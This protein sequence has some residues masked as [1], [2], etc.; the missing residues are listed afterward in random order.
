MTTDYCSQVRPEHWIEEIRD[1]RELRSDLGLGPPDLITPIDTRLKGNR[2]N[3]MSKKDA[4]A[5]LNELMNI[6]E[7]E[8]K[9][10]PSGQLGVDN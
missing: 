8:Q 7:L 10:A 3:S 5:L 4:P 2:R 9:T 1:E 6:E